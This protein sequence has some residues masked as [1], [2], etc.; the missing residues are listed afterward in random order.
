MESHQRM[1]DRQMHSLLLQMKRL[2]QEN[3]ELQAQMSASGP[4]QSRHPQSQ[5]IASRRTDEE[6]FPRNTEFSSGSYM[7]RFEEELSPTHQT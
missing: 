5:Q 3:E 1:S 6:S 2:K 7:T 4:F